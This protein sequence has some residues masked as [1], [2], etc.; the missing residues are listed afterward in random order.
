MK[1][2]RNVLVGIV[3]LLLCAAVTKARSRR[4]QN[5]ILAEETSRLPPDTTLPATST[6]T[7]TS[8]TSTRMATSICS[9]RRAPTARSR[10]PTG[11]CS[12]TAPARSPTSA[13][14]TCHSAIA[15][16]T[17]ADFGD[18]DRDGDVDAIVANLG[19]E[20]LLLNN[21]LGVFT[22]ASAQLPPSP[23]FLQ[24]I[25]ADARLADVDRDRDLDIL[26][27]NENPFNPSPTGGGQNRV[28]INDG[29][30]FFTDETALAPAGGQRS[31]RAPCCPATSIAIA[32]S[33]S[34][35]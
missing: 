8:W 4:V 7:S 32:T 35:S 25:T 24:D 20:Q 9:S 14:R 19:P 23:P 31:D 18:V 28:L 3:V 30:G 6:M 29:H 27:S 1:T 26:L 11:C 2:A 22:D 33:T 16:S 10:G 13:R 15:N 5:F 34:S 17:K 12:T 21:G